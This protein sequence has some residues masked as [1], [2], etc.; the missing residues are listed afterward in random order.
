MVE[1]SPGRGRRCGRDLAGHLL[2][3]HRSSLPSGGDDGCQPKHC[4]ERDL[5]AAWSG[6]D[7]RHAR[8]QSEPALSPPMVSARDGIAYNWHRH[9]DPTTRRNLRPDPLGFVDDGAASVKGFPTILTETTSSVGNGALIA[10]TMGI[11]RASARALLPDG[12]SI[13]GYARQSTIASG[14]ELRGMSR[15]R[16]P[17]V[18][19]VTADRGTAKIDLKMKADRVYSGSGVRCMREAFAAFICCAR[20]CSPG[21]GLCIG[22]NACVDGNELLG[23]ETPR[24]KSKRFSCEPLAPYTATLTPF[25]DDSIAKS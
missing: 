14:Q 23:P 4:V 12:P 16:A 11:P 24:L 18:R 1:R 15:L 20:L 6:A 17:M 5:N 19:S 8:H 9:Y 10:G 22:T 7:D 21:L 2:R 3:S 13:Y 25:A